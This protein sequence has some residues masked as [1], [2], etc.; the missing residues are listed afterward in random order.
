MFEVLA[1]RRKPIEAKFRRGFEGMTAEPASIDDLT[2]ARESLI[3]TVV[4]KMPEQDRRF[5]FSF[6]RGKAE[7]S[8]LE[9]PDASDLP[10]LVVTRI[11]MTN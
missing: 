5:L 8:L 9:L 6:E 1:P 7:W 11:E 3:D 4:G 2:S 10:A